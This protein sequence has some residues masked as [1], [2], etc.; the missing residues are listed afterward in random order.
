MRV[1][2]VHPDGRRI[3]GRIAIGQPRTLAGG[4]PAGDHETLCAIEITSIHS[5]LQLH[6][7]GSLQALLIAIRFAATR[8]HDFVENGGRV[9]HP[10]D[11]SDVDL[12]LLFGSWFAT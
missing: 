12:G 5:P 11:E 1:I 2:L 7:G 8:L 10:D 6:G 9:L 4:N 3:P